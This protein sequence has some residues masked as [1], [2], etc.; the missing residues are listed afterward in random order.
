LT[1]PS[2]DAAALAA[3]IEQLWRDPPLAA[4]LGEHAKTF[5]TANCG[6]ST[7]VNYLQDFLH[8]SVAPA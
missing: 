4:R 2:R 1:V 3:A 6:E 7:A 8:R 5:A